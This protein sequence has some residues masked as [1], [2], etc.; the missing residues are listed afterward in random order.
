M[1]AFLNNKSNYLFQHKVLFFAVFCVDQ[2]IG[3]FGGLGGYGN[4]GGG[5]GFG[6]YPGGFGGGGLGLGLGFGLLGG[7]PGFGYPW[8]APPLGFQ[9][10][11]GQIYGSPGI[12]FYNP[13]PSKQYMNV[14]GG[15]SGTG[16]QARAPL[17]KAV[18]GAL[19]NAA[20]SGSA[21]S[22]PAVNALGSK[23]QTVVNAATV[24]GAANN[25]MQALSPRAR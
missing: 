10:N 11:T 8:L 1:E 19:T 22:L 18:V 16:G 17:L 5:F 24:N 25:N 12:G 23:V 3:Q 9:I 7:Y 15:I 2:A 20:G 13:G 21:A 6:G 4:Y 14:A